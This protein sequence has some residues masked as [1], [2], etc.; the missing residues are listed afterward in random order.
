M[1]GETTPR[2]HAMR[3]GLGR[4]AREF[5]L[6]LRNPSDVGFY[7]LMPVALLGTLV[8]NRDVPVPGTPY[9]LPTTAMPG[10]I[11]AL[12]M[13][14]AMIGVAY[15]LAV[16]RED[17]TLLRA[18]A[19]PH[20]MV[21]YLTGQVT[22][23][24]LEAVFGLALVLIPGLL[25]FDNLASNGILT[26]VGMVWVTVLGLLAVLPLGAIIGSVVKG[27][28]AVAAWGMMPFLALVAISGIFY[29]MTALP[30]WVQVLGQVFPVYWLG[31]GMRA[32]FLPDAAVVAEIGESWRVLETVGVLG[33]W[34]VLGMLVAPVVL[35]RM[36]RRESGSKVE[37]YRQQAMQ[38]V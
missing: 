32:A 14:L 29:P 9:S 26:W 10:V 15:S 21:G 23:T 8:L 20:G 30:E 11:G 7:V 2:R 4:G 38:R 5:V 24:S 37:H 12:V 13:F 31:L 36:A 27:A 1:T 35:R 22:R 25:L 3:I 34:A 18:K 33:G 19:I 17:G 28:R 6:L 16:E